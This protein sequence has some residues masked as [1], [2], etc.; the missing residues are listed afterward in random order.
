MTVITIVLIAIVL[1][2]GTLLVNRMMASTAKK[3]ACSSLKI[4]HENTDK[5]TKKTV[6]NNPRKDTKNGGRPKRN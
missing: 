2:V 5:K 4:Q 6:K 3:Q 1:G